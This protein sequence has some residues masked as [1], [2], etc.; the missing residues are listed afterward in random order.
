[1]LCMHAMA[2][3][4]QD[5]MSLPMDRGIFAGMVSTQCSCMPSLTVVSHRRLPQNFWALTCCVV[6]CCVCRW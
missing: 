5:F 4:Q 2:P 6:L 3:C 1:M